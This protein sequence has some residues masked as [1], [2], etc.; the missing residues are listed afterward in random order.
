MSINGSGSQVRSVGGAL[1]TRCGCRM[2]H[3][4]QATER[5]FHGFLSEF[6]GFLISKLG[7]KAESKS[8]PKARAVFYTF[9]LVHFFF[10]E[11][12]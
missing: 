8:G 5:I 2:R 4:L 6:E 11:C 7:P 12:Y 3:L 1:T 10:F 9:S